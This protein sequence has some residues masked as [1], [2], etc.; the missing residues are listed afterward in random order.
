MSFSQGNLKGLAVAIIG[1]ISLNSYADKLDQAVKIDLAT[2]QAAAKSQKKI[3][4]LSEQT[5]K[6]LNEYRSVTR[7]TETL[8]T[9]NKHLQTLINSQLS[10]KKSLHAQLEEIETTQQ[11]IVPL[12][13]RMLDSLESFI[14]LDLPFLPEER[15]QRLVL[16]KN[17][18][19]RADV[20]NAEKFRRIMEAYQIEND[21]GNTIEAYRADLSL[22]G[23]NSSVDLLRLGRIALY[24]QRLDGSE[25]GFWNKETK[26]W[27]T[28]PS[29]YRN[30]IRN[31]LRIARKEA[32]PDLLVVPV[33]AP[34][35]AK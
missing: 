21:Y 2:N 16:L 5:Q 12:I 28:L 31:G 23:K 17:M 9:Y 4:N 8:I 7:Q 32:A 18:V 35:A 27:E 22:K 20:T 14:K 25:T 3:D 19:V 15:Q 29:D 34:E 24:Y 10:E 26:S 6:A 30:A 1:L 11:E 13:L 33:P